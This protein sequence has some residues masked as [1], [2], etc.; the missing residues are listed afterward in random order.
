MAFSFAINDAIIQCGN[1]R[2]Y[3]GTYTNTGGST[4]GKITLPV[5]ELISFDL[6]PKS[7]SVAANQPTYN[8]TLPSAIP[9]VTIVTDA[10]QVGYWQAFT[11]G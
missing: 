11:R 2:I 7:S 8:D 1:G 5:C 3:S 9:S 10:N 4:G 6:Q